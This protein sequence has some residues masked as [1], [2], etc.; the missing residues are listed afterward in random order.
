MDKANIMSATATPDREELLGRAI[1]ILARIHFETDRIDSTMINQIVNACGSKLNGFTDHTLSLICDPAIKPQWR[2][3]VTKGLFTSWDE[4]IVNDFLSN[5]QLLLDSTRSHGIWVITEHV[6][7]LGYYT[8][9]APLGAQHATERSQQTDA[10]IRVAFHIQNSGNDELIQKMTLKGDIRDHHIY[11]ADDQL[12]T[13]L[14]KSTYDR[15]TVLDFIL[16]RDMFDA[17]HITSILDAN[18]AKPLIEG[19]L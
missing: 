15:K 13:L 8:E 11:I 3:L 19:A 17:D 12:R 18:I 4:Q 6:K 9:L 2:T 5:A 10:I 1:L 14:L 16:Q 7:V